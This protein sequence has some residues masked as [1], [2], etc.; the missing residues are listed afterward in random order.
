MCG[1]EAKLLASGGTMNQPVFGHVLGLAESAPLSAGGGGRLNM[2]LLPVLRFPSGKRYFGSEYA[3]WRARGEVAMPPH[4]A[5]P[6]HSKPS[7]NHPLAPLS[8][9]PEL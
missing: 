2:S 8:L 1:W 9:L 7:P 5:N 3:V 6:T 4:E